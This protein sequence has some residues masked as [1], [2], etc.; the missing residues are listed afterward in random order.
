MRKPRPEDYDPKYKDSKGPKPDDIDLSDVV[1]LKTRKNPL[2]SESV[3]EDMQKRTKAN[4]PLKDNP[5]FKTPENRGEVSSEETKDKEGNLLASKLA[6]LQANM[7]TSMQ[8]FLRERASYT[9]AF[10]YPPELVEK[11]EDTLHLIKK[12][13]KAKLTK[14]SVAVA[15]MVFLLTDYE[16]NGAKSMLYQLLIETKPE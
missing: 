15:A 5:L 6:S 7:Q 12:Q 4:N 10:R 11:L 8:A 16:L 2:E 13:H 1:P 3:I 14:N 9:V